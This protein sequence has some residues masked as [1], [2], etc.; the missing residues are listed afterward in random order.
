MVDL[1]CERLGPAIWAEPINALTNLAFFVAAW[2]TWRLAYRRQMFSFGLWQLI[3][4]IV[5]IGAGSM[6]FHTFATNWAR[7]L[8][9][10][11]ILL[12]QLVYLWLYSCYIIN[13]R[14]AYAAGLLIA[15]LIAAYIGRQFPHIL[16][17]S[18]IYAPAFLLLLGLGLYHYFKRKNERT[19]LLVATG[20]FTLSL[21]FRTIDHSICPYFSIGTHFFWHIF[22]S[23][24][25]YLLVRGLLANISGNKKSSL[26]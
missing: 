1:Y 3:A 7:A 16:N 17:G 18:L 15:Y 12:F 10:L 21:F 19:L 22:N 6:L 25:L 11:P 5:I 14:Y 2:A 20:V 4:L 26:L 9:V 23:V 8:D 24:L 13:M